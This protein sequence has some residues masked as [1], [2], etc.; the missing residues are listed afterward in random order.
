MSRDIGKWAFINL[1]RCVYDWIVS[2]EP[3]EFVAPVEVDPVD[4]EEQSVLDE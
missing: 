1:I 2:R 3:A 4:V